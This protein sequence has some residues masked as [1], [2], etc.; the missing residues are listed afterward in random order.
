MTH[1][2]TNKPND[3]TQYRN[4]TEPRTA[5]VGVFDNGRLEVYICANDKE[6]VPHV[7]ICGKSEWGDWSDTSAVKLLDCHYYLHGKHDY[8]FTATVKRKF[9][10]FMREKPQDGR[11]RTNYELA[12]DLWNRLNPNALAELK[13]HTNG[14]PKIPDYENLLPIDSNEDN[15]FF[16][17]IRTYDIARIGFFDD[18]RIEVFVVTDDTL[19]HPHL[20]IRDRYTL[21]R[22]F[23]TAVDLK[24]AQYTVS[25]SPCRF[26]DCQKELFIK[27]LRAKHNSKVS[28]KE[29]TNYEYAVEMWNSQNSDFC[30][31]KLPDNGKLQ[32]P[33]YKQLQTINEGES[34]FYKAVSIG[35][36]YRGLFEAYISTDDEKTPHI[37]IRDYN[38][39]G[40]EHTSVVDLR[41][42]QYVRPH[43]DCIML[44]SQSKE[45]ARF[46]LSKPESGQFAT[47]YE[48]AID[49]WNRYN[50]DSPMEPVRTE[51]G[52]IIVPEYDDLWPLP[53]GDPEFDWWIHEYATVRWFNN[54]RMR[55]LVTQMREEMAEKPYFKLMN[56]A[57][58]NTRWAR[59]RFD[60]PHYADGSADK[61]QWRL[62]ADERRWLVTALRQ[63]DGDRMYSPDGQPITLWQ[64]LIT[65]FNRENG[66]DLLPPDLPMP[67]YTLLK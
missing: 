30:K 65:S 45:F 22:E 67:D 63:P 52:Q 7:H 50:P 29:M 17:W 41:T 34:P 35:R 20:H 60:S 59:I 18:G 57:E 48:L 32:M 42:N 27:F 8:V 55:L 16:G 3:F 36:F 62:N 23:M 15:D 58:P 40:Q 61:Y 5:R 21:G 37:H 64:Q 11:F 28:C 24:T 10:R 31:M 12:I 39:M 14:R 44:H 13:R 53:D 46:M 66:T 25:H 6:Q 19:S 2:N 51:S 43:T 33:D 38:T 54:E 26:T 4:T 9:A 1:N 49:L 56:Y 47:N